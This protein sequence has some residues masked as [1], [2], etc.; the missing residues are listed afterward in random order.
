MHSK[1]KHLLVW[2]SAFILGACQTSPKKNNEKAGPNEELASIP[3][4]EKLTSGPGYHWFGYYDKL[5]VDPSGRYILG[6]KVGFEGRS[7][8]ATDSLEIGMVDTQNENTWVK[9]GYS[10]A[11]GW[12]QGCML[13]WIPGAGKE[14]TWNDREGDRFVSRVYNVETKEVRTLPRAIYTL[15]PNGQ[16]ALCTDFN[17]I[18][19]MRP[20]Y[21]YAGLPDPHGTERAPGQIG[22]YKMDLQTGESQMILSIAEVAEIDTSPDSVKNYWHYF[23]HLLIS[24]NS[25]RFVFLHRKRKLKPSE[26]GSK[27]GGFI[28]R[29][30]SANVD[31]SDLFLLDPSGKTSHFIWKE[32]E[33]L[34]AWTKPAGEQWGFYLLYDKSGRIDRIAPAK[35]P[36]NGHN[37]YVPGTNYE[38]ILNDTYPG[39]EDRLQTLYLYH[40]LTDRRIELGQFHAPGMYKGEWRCDLHPKA[41]PGGKWVIFDSTHEGDGRQMYR[42]DI[43]DIIKSI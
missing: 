3:K 20:G 16:F 28:T 17:R 9:L 42:V 29:M 43:S 38:W 30:F 7:P 18:Q 13:Q 14:I 26:T 21:G 34:C 37:T 27:R 24:P 2:I 32:N 19:D 5:Q 10:N 11:W 22:I 4:V 33:A 1:L 35:M 8:T 25:E 31:G 39:K 40:V 12:Q 15:S 36:K 23:N 6:A 41:S